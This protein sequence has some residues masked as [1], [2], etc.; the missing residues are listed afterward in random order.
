MNKIDECIALEKQYKDKLKE[1]EV[2]FS[3]IYSAKIDGNNIIFDDIDN[4][5]CL[6]LMHATTLQNWLVK[7]LGDK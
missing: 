1:L 3:H 4:S 7:I 2:K 6:P 5:F